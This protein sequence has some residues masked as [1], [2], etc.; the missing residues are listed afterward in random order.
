MKR[1]LGRWTTL[2][3]IL[4]LLVNLMSPAFAAESQIDVNAY[5][6]GNELD[7]LIN[8]ILNNTVNDELTSEDLITA[9]KNGIFELVDEHSHYYDEEGFNGLNA[10]TS[11]NFGGIGAMVEFVDGFYHVKGFVDDSPA[12]EA[13]LRVGDKFIVVNGV[14][15]E[16]LPA[17]KAIS[18]IR[19]EVDSNARVGIMRGQSTRVQYYEITRKLI[20]NN[21]ISL[22]LGKNDD[23]LDDNMAYLRISQFNANTLLNMQSTF[24]QLEEE[25]VDKVIFDL[26]DNPGGYLDQVLEVLKMIVVNDDLLHVQYKDNAKNFRSDLKTAPFEIAVLVNG[27]S[28]SASEIFA[29]AIQDTHS[30]IIIGDQTYGKGSVQGIFPLTNKEGFKMTIA[31]YFTPDWHKVNGVGITPDIII[32]QTLPMETLL[33]DF[34]MANEQ[35]TLKYLQK[36]KTIQTVK[37]QL[38]YLGYEVDPSDDLFNQEL[39]YVLPQFQRDFRINLSY[40]LDPET[41]ATL[42]ALTTGNNAYYRYLAKNLYEDDAFARAIE[43]LRK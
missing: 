19:G 17:S 24:A 25:G 34:P 37:A 11:G 43:E 27:N 41:Q 14:P 42:N 26:R 40:R 12:K 6:L 15:L 20:H 21:P 2:A 38:A 1:Q 23:K 28:A 18:H 7:Y 3:V 30:G 36:S 31:E 16:G 39:A 33:A 10:S 9:A 22:I 13:G 29:G 4:I 8:Y 32:P 35:S 5:R